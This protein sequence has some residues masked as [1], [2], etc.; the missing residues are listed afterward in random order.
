METMHGDSCGHKK[1]YP[2]ERQV[3]RQCQHAQCRE[4]RIRT[5]NPPDR[6]EPKEKGGA[7]DPVPF[8]RVCARSFFA[9]KNS[10]ADWHCQC[11][12]RTVHRRQCQVIAESAEQKPKERG[13]DNSGDDV[14]GVE[15]V[16]RKRIGKMQ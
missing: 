12:R 3:R 4:R 15:G 2:V 5:G 6:G 16:I 14:H 11:K 7:I 8:Y 9:K 13:S 1:E 10:P